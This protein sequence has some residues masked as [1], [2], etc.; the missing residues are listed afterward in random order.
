MILFS[1][2]SSIY[3]DFGHVEGVLARRKSFRKLDQE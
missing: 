3:L 1:T 2:N